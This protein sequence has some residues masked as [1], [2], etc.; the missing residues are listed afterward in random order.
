MNYKVS[1]KVANKMTTPSLSAVSLDNEIGVRF[2]KFIDKRVTGEFAINEI[3]REA[4]EFFKTKFDDE[5]GAGM[6]RSEFYGKLMLSFARVAAMKNNERLKHEIEK[7][8]DSFLSNQEADGYISTYHGRRNLFGADKSDPSYAVIGWDSNW[9]FWGQKYT[10]WALIECA[11]LLDSERI[12]D[13]AVRLADA[14]LSVVS[15][16]GVRVRDLGVQH[17]MAA[18]SIIKPML[19]LYRLTGDERYLDFS[20]EI[21]KDWDREDGARPNL[22]ANPKSGVPLHK[23]YKREDGWHPKAYEMMSCY[24]GLIE[25]YRL[26][27]NSLYLDATVNFADLLIKHETNI[28]GS[29]GYG[30]L[31][32]NASAY[33][34]AATEICDVIHWMRICHEL[35]LITGDAKYTEN[36]ES[37]FL[38]AFLA[39]IYPDEGWCAFFVRSTGRHWAQAPQCDSK[40]QHCCA[41]NVPR[42][43][44]NAAETIITESDGDYYI[45]SY[46]PAT[47]TLGDVSFRISSGYVNDGKVTITARGLKPGTRV[48]LRAPIWSETTIATLYHEGG[49]VELNRGE[50]TP[51]TVNNKH[52][53]I[54]V[55]FDMRP[56]LIPFDGEVTE[57]PA[58]DYHVE[59]WIDPR[60]GLC[61][62]ALMTKKP[63]CT[64]RRGP[65]VLARSKRLGATREEMFDSDSVFGKNAK[66]SAICAYQPGLLALVYVTVSV[67][68]EKKTYTMCDLASAANTNTLDVHYF[69]IYV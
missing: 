26:T 41:N 12:L 47:V 6:W 52:S 25:L 15:E 34:D 31:F 29:V 28:L 3:L 14:L 42:G 69:T 7:S 54:G 48:Y 19:K 55:S 45:N 9:N 10:L 5:F 56:R 58:T 53:V 1:Y 49:N 23:W 67:D 62:R 38:N 66:C 51:V 60:N 32:Y 61:N 13:S 37:A 40:Y 18:G 44:V 57:L 16:L 11:M 46:I 64:I 65:L 20:I 17:G 2:D 50:Y 63:I 39:G 59:R 36:F 35:F 22:I 4:E 27:G 43:F 24:D 68:G 8:L 21:A 33:P 30:E